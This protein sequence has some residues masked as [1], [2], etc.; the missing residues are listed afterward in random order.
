MRSHPD[1]GNSGQ[2]SIDF[3]IGMLVFAGVVLF[4]FQFMTTTILPFSEATGD[5]TVKVH[6]VGDKLYY[7]TERLSTGEHGKVDMT[8]FKD[9]LTDLKSESQLKNELAIDDETSS[10]NI[11]VFVHNESGPNDVA[12]LS[13]AGNITIGPSTPESGAS[14]A[15]ATRIGYWEKKAEKVIINIRMW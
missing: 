1:S 10:L 14:V 15:R 9:G 3:L 5:K 13:G 8:Y 6:S 4:V 11:T 7:D 2:M 12:K